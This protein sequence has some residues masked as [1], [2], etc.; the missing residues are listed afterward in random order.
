M[1]F[2]EVVFREG[3]AAL[4]ILPSLIDTLPEA[5]LNLI[6]F[7]LKRGIPITAIT[8]QSELIMIELH[9]VEIKCWMLFK[10][11]FGHLSYCRHNFQNLLVSLHWDNSIFYQLKW[12]LLSSKAKFLHHQLF[13]LQFSTVYPS[14]ILQLDGFTLAYC[15]PGYI[16]PTRLQ[17]NEM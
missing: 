5:R 13:R 3:D 7:H 11:H 1:N 16:L 9:L 14:F 10:K 12:M 8:K 6:I 4:Q 2:I 17:G 15:S